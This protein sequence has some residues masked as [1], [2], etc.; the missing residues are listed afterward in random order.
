[1]FS[2]DFLRLNLLVLWGQFLDRQGQVRLAQAQVFQERLVALR[3]IEDLPAC[4]PFQVIRLE[5]P[6]PTFWTF[7]EI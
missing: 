1:M 5:C 6:I 4:F 2:I 7:Y 3:S